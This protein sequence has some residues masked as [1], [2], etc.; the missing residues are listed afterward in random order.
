M[1][2][3]KSTTADLKVRP[4]AERIQRI[5][6]RK[7]ET[8]LVGENALDHGANVGSIIGVD[9]E[10]KGNDN[11]SAKA[12]AALEVVAL[13]VADEVVDHKNG[14]EE[15]DGL[16]ALEV[17]SHRLAHDPAEDDEER[18]DEERDL[19]AAADR[20]T[21]GQVHL[22]FVCDDASGNVFGGVADNGQE[23]E[24][25]E[26]LADVEGIDDG[27]NAVNQVFGAN[28]DKHSDEDKAD[29]SCDGVEDLRLVRLFI[30]ALLLLLGIEQ[31]GVRLELEEEV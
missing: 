29:C 17:E 13:A 3:I 24:T 22:V 20:N 9:V 8:N 26:G 30:A 15:D 4:A 12:H 25:D 11:V 10:R 1:N 2:R 5:Q 6:Q 31:V 7:S 27:V 18:S 23:N 19:H 14:K 21:D 16:E 28:G